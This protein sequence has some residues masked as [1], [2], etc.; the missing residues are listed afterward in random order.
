MQTH[1][2]SG[3][4]NPICAYSPKTPFQVR[5]SLNQCFQHKPSSTTL[6][7]NGSNRHL[8]VSS[9]LMLA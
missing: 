8:Q 4:I 2:Y 3:L 9:S 1:F 6:G 7:F 5:I